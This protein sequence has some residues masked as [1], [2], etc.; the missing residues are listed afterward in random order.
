MTVPDL[1]EVNV[2]R[3]ANGFPSPMGGPASG[4]CVG[5]GIPRF[6]GALISLKYHD[7]PG[8][9]QVLHGLLTPINA[10]EFIRRCLWPSY[11][12]RDPIGERVVIVTT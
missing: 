12:Q 7:Q 8:A 1:K 11:R 5:A 4:V 9:L 2:P 3:A 10:E 6:A